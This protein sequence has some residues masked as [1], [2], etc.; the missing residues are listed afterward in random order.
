MKAK[1]ITLALIVAG[2]I[3]PGLLQ[4]QDK[5]PVSNRFSIKQTV[6]FAMQNSVQVR[7]ALLDLQIQQ[8]TNRQITSAAMP[9]LSASGNYTNYLVIP[10]TLLPAEIAGGTPG[11]FLPV[12]FGVPHNV[13]GSFD[14]QQVLFDGQVFVG[15]QARRA[16]LDFYRRQSDVTKEQIKA[17]VYKIYYQLVVG[18]QQLGAIDANIERFEKLLTDTRAIYDNG[19]AEKLD[20]DKVNVQLSNLQT[21]KL[22]IQ[23]QLDAGLVALKF[24]INMPQKD[25]LLLTDTLSEKEL[26]ENLLDQSY[27]YADRPEYKLLQVAQDLGRYNIKRY[28]LSALPSVSAFASYSK[29]ALRQQFNFF[30]DGSWFTTSVVGIGLKFNIFDGFSRKAN[31]AKARLELEQT[32][33]NIEQ[34]KASIDNDVEQA[35]LKIAAALKTVDNQKRNMDLAVQVFQSTKLK[36][37]QGLGSNQE[38]YSAQTELKVAQANYYGALYDAIVARVDFLKAIGKL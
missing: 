18:K 5:A 8:Q 3:I 6:D 32:N 25:S 11:T 17:N 35:R 38:I 16:S 24:L 30:N 14:L 12:Q 22:R 29:N 33:N 27:N 23:S 31:L 9:K 34:L 7:N 4:A 26:K 28:K 19:F 10:T 2:A 37:E 21:E 1:N 20:V 13:T 15:L 36:Y